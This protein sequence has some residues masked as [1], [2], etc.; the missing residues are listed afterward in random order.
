MGSSQ[1]NQ[2]AAADTSVNLHDISQGAADAGDLFKSV[3]MLNQA[4]LECI[5]RCARVNE[6]LAATTFGVPTDAVRRVAKMSFIEISV[7]AK[8]PTPLFR[9]A[10]PATW[11]AQYLDRADSDVRDRGVAMSL[12]N[13]FAAGHAA[14]GTTV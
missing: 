9:S 3:Y 1:I 4:F 14:T 2:S 8:L 12:G 13:V 7:A 10:H 5:Q 6:N 11:W